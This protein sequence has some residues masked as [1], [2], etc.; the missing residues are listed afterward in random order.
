MRSATTM[1]GIPHTI[2]ALIMM[3]TL[4]LDTTT[5]FMAGGATS[6]LLSSNGTINITSH[7]DFE[8]EFLMD[9][10]IN[11]RVLAK[12]I[13]T[14]ASGTGNPRGPICGAARGKRYGRCQGPRTDKRPYLKPSNTPEPP[15]R[16]VA[17]SN[18]RALELGQEVRWSL[19]EHASAQTHGALYPAQPNGAN[20]QTYH[21]HGWACV[22]YSPI[23]ASSKQI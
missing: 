21:A 8:Q 15:R 9:S 10:E 7:Q 1:R 4:I 22:T 6:I 19:L 23:W 14:G 18:W 20:T 13:K 5:K 3:T 11:R 16:Q 17:S 2:V 12:S